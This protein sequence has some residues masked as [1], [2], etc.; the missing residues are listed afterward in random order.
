MSDDPFTCP[1]CG[2]PMYADAR[3]G[4][5]FHRCAQCRGVFV[6]YAVFEALLPGNQPLIAEPPPEHGYP[7]HY[8][9][10]DHGHARSRPRPTFGPGW[11]GTALARGTRPD[12]ARLLWGR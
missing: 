4:V 1:Q 8:P 2:A 11:G 10:Q 3:R 12:A 6:E 9:Q 5:R 7:V